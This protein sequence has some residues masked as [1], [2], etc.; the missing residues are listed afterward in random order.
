MLNALRPQ[1]DSPE[2]G[3]CGDEGHLQAVERPAPRSRH[4]PAV[5]SQ[6]LFKV[7]LLKRWL[8]DGRI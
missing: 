4:R 5:S 2:C 6:K 7:A 8:L 3:V 1:A